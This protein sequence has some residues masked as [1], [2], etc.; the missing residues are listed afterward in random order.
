MLDPIAAMPDSSPTPTAAQSQ[1][2]AA[3]GEAPI[4]TTLS[5][6]PSGPVR[7]SSKPSPRARRARLV[8]SAV[9]YPG[10]GPKRTRISGTTRNAPA[11]KTI[12]VAGMH[13]PTDFS[14]CGPAGYSPSSAAASSSPTAFSPSS[15]PCAL[16]PSPFRTP[17]LFLFSCRLSWWCLRLSPWGLCSHRHLDAGWNLH[18]T[19]GNIQMPLAAEVLT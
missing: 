14:T 10:C 11:G 2:E 16:N 15:P 6:H 18:D 19:S 3:G 5:R 12:A 13:P 4:A 9:G 8:R 1:P 7:L 17:C